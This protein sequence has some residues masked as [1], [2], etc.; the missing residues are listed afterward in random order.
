M[1]S[2]TETPETTWIFIIWAPGE[3][4]YDAYRTDD[5]QHIYGHKYPLYVSMCPGNYWKVIQEVHRSHLQGIALTGEGCLS[6]FTA[7]SSVLVE[8]SPLM[9]FFN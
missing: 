7:H 1:A 4:N 2:I 5:M 9:Y 3:R 8:F 6:L